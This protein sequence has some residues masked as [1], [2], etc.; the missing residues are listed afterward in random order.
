VTESAIGGA[1]GA[2][3]T[4]PHWLDA[5]PSGRPAVIVA[6][7]LWVWWGPWRPDRSR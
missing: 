7:G 6:D 3:G 5:L 1:A 2:A 4:D